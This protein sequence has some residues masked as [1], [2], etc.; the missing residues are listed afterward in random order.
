MTRAREAGQNSRLFKLYLVCPTDVARRLCF[1]QVLDNGVVTALGSGDQRCKAP[2]ANILWGQRA[3]PIRSSAR[4]THALLELETHSTQWF[5]YNY[6][7]RN[8][9]VGVGIEK[10]T[11]D[12]AVPGIGRDQ[13]GGVSCDD[14]QAC[15][16]RLEPA[17]TAVDG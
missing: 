15:G 9:R 12:L 5:Y 3:H 16:S 11:H 6:L 13:Q 8:A 4:R 10:L 2:L 17:N 1:K 14:A 7:I